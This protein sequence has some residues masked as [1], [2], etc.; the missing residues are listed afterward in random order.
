MCGEMGYC[1]A[2]RERGRNVR[3]LLEKFRWGRLISW[4]RAVVVEMKRSGHI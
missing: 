4:T 1:E 3:K 2:N